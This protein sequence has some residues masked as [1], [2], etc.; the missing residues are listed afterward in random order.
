MFLGA[1]ELYLLLMTDE[2]GALYEKSGIG[3]KYTN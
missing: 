2:S 3:E 1:V